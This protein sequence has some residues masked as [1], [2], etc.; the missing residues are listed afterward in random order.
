MHDGKGSRVTPIFPELA[1]LFRNAFEV[2]ED[3]AEHVITRYR[4]PNQNLRTHLLRIMKRAGV[5]PWPK[6]FVNLRATRATELA[7][8]YPAHVCE[9]WLGHSEE[10]AR[11][12]Y[13]MTTDEHFAKATDGAAQKAAQ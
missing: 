12:H 6:L 2:A 1:S 13:L 11:K 3:G 4:C 8:T 10:I 9:S 5:T 7:E